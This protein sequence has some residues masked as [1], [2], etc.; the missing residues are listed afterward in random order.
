MPKPPTRP[1]ESSIKASLA[2]WLLLTTSPDFA[3]YQQPTKK[4]R[5][6]IIPNGWD[7]NNLPANMKDLGTPASITELLDFLANTKTTAKPFKGSL[8]WRHFIV[9]QHAF[10]LAMN[11]K[12]HHSAKRFAA[13]DL[14]DPYPP[15]DP[16]C[17]RDVTYIDRLAMAYPASGPPPVTERGTKEKATTTK[18]AKK[19]ASA[20]RTGKKVAV[21]TSINL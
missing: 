6:V 1:F 3:D 18:P 7:P 10:Q 16:S 20:K 21:K 13:L 19:V 8:L 11:T 4:K 5:G 2:F 9:V 17:P 14:P 12:S 15:D